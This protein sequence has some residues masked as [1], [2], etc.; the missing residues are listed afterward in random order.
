[1]A[2]RAFLFI[3]L[4]FSFWVQLSIVRLS[5]KKKFTCCDQKR[6]KFF[7]RNFITKKRP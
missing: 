5:G 3:Y 6:T 1:V 7:Q 4:F 2:L